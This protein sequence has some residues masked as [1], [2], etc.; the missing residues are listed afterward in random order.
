M[1][2][3]DLDDT[4]YKE[5]NYVLSGYNAVARQVSLESGLDARIV[6]GR[7]L[8]ASDP[9]AEAAKSGTMPLETYVMLY[10]HH[11]PSIS[12]DPAALNL[13]NALRE[14]N[15]PMAMITDGR[16]VGQRNKFLALGLDRFIPQ[17]RLLI[18][19]ETGAEKT[20]PLPFERIMEMYPDEKSWI[21]IGDN[22]AKDFFH[23]R[24]LGWKTIMLID[25][26]RENIHSQQDIPS[27]AHAA[28]YSVPSLT[29]ALPLII[30][31]I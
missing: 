10:R 31:N 14:R 16:S 22:P 9:L 28:D 15:I 20:S 5:H 13:L 3:F 27:E 24:A 2:V 21:Y 6:L 7:M 12:L 1:V 23:P 19:A 30:D 17:E 4:L 26:R 11:Y 29:Q 25:V 18:S 8:L